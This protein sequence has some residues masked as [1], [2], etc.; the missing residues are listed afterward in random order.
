MQ[1]YALFDDN[2]KATDGVG[3]VVTFPDFQWGITQGDTEEE[4]REMAVDALLLM[5]GEH[6]RKGEPLPRPSRP[7]G[8]KYRSIELPAMESA[9]MELYNAFR[10]AGITK[11]ELARRVGIPKTTVDRL[12]DFRNHTRLDQLEAAFRALGKHVS[13]EVRDAA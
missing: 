12:F 4:A 9:K 3:F 7:R 11:A 1:Y 13:I 8:K 6:I 5:I 2:P 10:A